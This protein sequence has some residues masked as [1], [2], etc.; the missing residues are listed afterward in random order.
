M[1]SDLKKALLGGTDYLETVKL[2]RGEDEDPLEVQVRPLS[3]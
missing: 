3:G 1:G 2:S